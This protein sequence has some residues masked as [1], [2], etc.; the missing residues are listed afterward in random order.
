[1]KKLLLSVLLISILGVTIW[2]YTETKNPIPSA[3]DYVD[4]KTKE[5][6]S[7]KEGT[8][9]QNDERIASYWR[10][11]NRVYIEQDNGVTL[12]GRIFRGSI[13]LDVN[14]TEHLLVINKG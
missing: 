14:G 10:L 6:Y 12:K 5:I 7:F 11:H 9:T 13:R 8:V 4:L 1:M 3:W 2:A